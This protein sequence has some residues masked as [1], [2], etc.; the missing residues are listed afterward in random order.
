LKNTAIPQISEQFRV[1]LRA[2]FFN[3]ANHPNFG[4][5]GLRLVDNRGNY[6][7]RAGV[8]TSTANGTTARQIQFGLK[9]MW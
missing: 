5:P 8:I 1:Q 7:R 6:D 9:F 2:E 3:M 4:L